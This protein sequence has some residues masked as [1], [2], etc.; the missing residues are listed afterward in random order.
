MLDDT[1]TC[2]QRLDEERRLWEQ[3]LQ[4][5]AQQQQ[6]LLTDTYQQRLWSIQHQLREQ[7][8]Q[9]VQQLKVEHEGRMQAVRGQ[10]QVFCNPDHS[11][12]LNTSWCALATRTVVFEVHA[13]AA[14]WYALCGKQ[15]R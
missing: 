3:Q 2:R 7:E 11:R 9:V 15:N 4:T 12:C 8:A 14:S 10:L 13:M 6:T 1:G 5:E